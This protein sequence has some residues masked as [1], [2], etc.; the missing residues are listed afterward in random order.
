M[1]SVAEQGATR[2]NICTIISALPGNDVGL[3]SVQRVKSHMGYRAKTHYSTTLLG[4]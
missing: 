4:I 2:L 1:C 3:K